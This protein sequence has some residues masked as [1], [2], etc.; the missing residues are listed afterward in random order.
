MRPSSGAYEDS[1]RCSRG[2]QAFVFEH[3]H[4]ASIAAGQNVGVRV[5]L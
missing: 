2:L 1:P 5:L 3:R 4:R